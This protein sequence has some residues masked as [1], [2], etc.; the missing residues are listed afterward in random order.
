[1]IHCI[2]VNERRVERNE[3]DQCAKDCNKSAD[4]N[5]Q[6]IDD[7]NKVAMSNNLACKKHIEVLD[8]CNKQRIEYDKVKSIREQREGRRNRT[9]CRS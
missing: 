4:I 3:N 9:Q 6:I 2:D 7:C 5:N 1:M 8:L